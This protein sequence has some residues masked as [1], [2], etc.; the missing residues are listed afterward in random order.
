MFG[1]KKLF[2]DFLAKFLSPLPPPPIPETIG[3]PG[4]TDQSAINSCDTY[5]HVNIIEFSSFT[6]ELT[7]SCFQ[8]FNILKYDFNT[9]PQVL[10]CLN[11]LPVFLPVTS[12]KWPVQIDFISMMII[13]VT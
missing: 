9:K 13:L 10:Y 3:N 7:T 6:K 12:N 11:L 4:L 8:L 2:A 5:C 1:K